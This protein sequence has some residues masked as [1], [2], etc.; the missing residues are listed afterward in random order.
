MQ[1]KHKVWKRF[2]T[3]G[4]GESMIMAARHKDDHLMLRL[5]IRNGGESFTYATMM[6]SKEDAEDTMKMLNTLMDTLREVRED[7][8]K[9]DWN[10]PQASDESKNSQISSTDVDAGLMVD[11]D[12]L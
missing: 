4:P 5:V 6:R 2:L 7:I 10:A 12:N 11:N 9:V 8:L 1:D 3:D